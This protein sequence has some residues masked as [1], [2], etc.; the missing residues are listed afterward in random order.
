MKTSLTP[1]NDGPCGSL[2]PDGNRT[3]SYPTRKTKAKVDGETTQDIVIAIAMVM[4]RMGVTNLVSV[5]EF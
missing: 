1:M 3:G 5:V 2:I 4:D